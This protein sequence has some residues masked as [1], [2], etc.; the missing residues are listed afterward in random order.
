MTKKA[1]KKRGPKK[2]VG[3]RRRYDIR[4]YLWEGED[5]DLI[6]FLEGLPDRQRPAGIKL[7]LRSGGALSDLQSSA[8]K[9]EENDMDYDMGA[10]LA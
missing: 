10:F 5:D 9:D 8:L 7:A 6:A 2:K 1:A 4:L 3:V